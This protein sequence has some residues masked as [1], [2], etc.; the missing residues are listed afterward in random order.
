M[1]NAAT[2]IAATVVTIS[3]V[4]AGAL[5]MGGE[6][7]A[8]PATIPTP[9]Y[10]GNTV[11]GFV[12]QVFRWQASPEATGYRLFLDGKVISLVNYTASSIA[13]QCGVPHRFNV[14]PF[15]NKGVAKLPTPVY[16]TVAC[17]KATT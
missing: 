12:V 8:A 11:P 16:L 7:S 13:I 2:A 4:T 10:D 9:V 6:H 14:Q 5:M 15:N 17:D 1:L 3:G